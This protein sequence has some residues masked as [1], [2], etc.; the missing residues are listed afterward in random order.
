MVARGHRQPRRVGPQGQHL[1]DG[2]TGDGRGEPCSRARVD[3]GPER[4]VAP[5]D[6][7]DLEPLR[8]RVGGRVVAGSREEDE[9]RVARPGLEGEIALR[10]GDR[11]DLG[12]VADVDLVTGE[13]LR[14]CR[15]VA[16]RIPGSESGRWTILVAFTIGVTNARTEA[17]NRISSKSSVS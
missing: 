11:G 17:I 16:R 12:I 9:D 5:V 3:A 2:R 7:V 8:V 13:Q 14:R 10:P 15:G 1:G 4:S 6:A